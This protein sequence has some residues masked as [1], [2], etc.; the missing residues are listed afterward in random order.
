VARVLGLDADELDVG[1]GLFDLGLDSLMVVELRRALEAATGCALPTTLVFNHPT[2]AALSAFLG[3]A[4]LKLEVPEVPGPWTDSGTAGES[5][6][7][8][9]LSE[10][11]L[12][13]LLAEKLAQLP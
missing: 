8:P 13:A 1:R 12:A 11:D 7:R 10:Q 4:A 9:D 2:V 5:S 3:A 6:E